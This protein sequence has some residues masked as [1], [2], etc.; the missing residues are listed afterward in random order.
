MEPIGQ[1]TYKLRDFKNAVLT[2]ELLAENSNIGRQI[3]SSLTLKNKTYIDLYTY[4][5]KLIEAENSENK[6]S[7]EQKQANYSY[8]TVDENKLVIVDFQT[9]KGIVGIEQNNS[10]SYPEPGKKAFM[11]GKSAPDG[12]YKF[13]FLWYVH[14]KN[15]VV[16]SFSLL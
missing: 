2:F 11:N 6:F 16:T 7:N 15:G 13:G 3:K 14:I 5:K 10:Y 1:K 12:K 8:E 9:N 4:F